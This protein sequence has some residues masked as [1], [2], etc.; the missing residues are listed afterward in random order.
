M[1]QSQWEWKEKESDQ[2]SI[3]TAGCTLLVPSTCC[4]NVT[5]DMSHC[6]ISSPMHMTNDVIC[7]KHI[8]STKTI[9]HCTQYMVISFSAAPV[10]RYHHHPTCHHHHNHYHH[11]HH[12]HPCHHHHR[13]HHVCSA[14]LSFKSSQASVSSSSQSRWWS[15][16]WQWWRCNDLMIVILMIKRIESFFIINV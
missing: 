14:S 8:I 2:R 11:C 12:H 4:L 6:L 1:L 10:S 3:C 13:N 7:R 16:L 5:T 9:R 15:K